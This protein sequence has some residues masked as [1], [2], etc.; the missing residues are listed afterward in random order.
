MNSCDLFLSRWI[1]TDYK[2]SGSKSLCKCSWK[3]VPGTVQRDPKNGQK[4]PFLGIFGPFFGPLFGPVY[5]ALLVISGSKTGKIGVLVSVSG[6]PLG[7]VIPSVNDPFWTPFW[8]PFLSQNPSESHLNR[9][10]KGSKKG[11]F[12]RDYA[13]YSVIKYPFFGPLF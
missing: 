5:M 13:A 7:H 4:W 10:K 1:R 2:G 12:L 11:H 9:S 3:G 8:T 6:T